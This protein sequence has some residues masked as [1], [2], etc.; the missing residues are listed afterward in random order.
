MDGYIA[1]RSRLDEA[2]AACVGPNIDAAR[3]CLRR[4]IEGPERPALPI[5][6]AG[7]R[8]EL[9]PPRIEM[10]DRLAQSVHLIPVGGDR[11]VDRH[12][13]DAEVAT[14]TEWL[15]LVDDDTELRLYRHEGWQRS[16]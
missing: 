14:L 13:P 10:G 6:L 15:Q 2:I 8:Y 3:P 4:R 12:A 9:V 5:D 11:W 1:I 16:T 7:E